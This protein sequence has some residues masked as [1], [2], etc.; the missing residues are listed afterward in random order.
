MALVTTVAVVVAM[1]EV[2]GMRVGTKNVAEIL[3]AAMTTTML[4]AVAVKNNG[5]TL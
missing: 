3:V 1:V 4:V 2:E 5:L